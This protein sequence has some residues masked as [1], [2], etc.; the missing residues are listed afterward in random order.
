MLISSTPD[1]NMRELVYES[2]FFSVYLAATK[3]RARW[4]QARRI[5][6]P[7]CPN[8]RIPNRFLREGIKPAQTPHWT[9]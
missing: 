5:F 9:V 8:L 3:K 7:S 4:F 1:K 2:V 6:S